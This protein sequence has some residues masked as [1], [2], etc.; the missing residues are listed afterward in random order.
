MAVRAPCHPAPLMAGASLQRI[1]IYLG[2]SPGTDPA[3]AAGV[4]ALAREC[5][6]RGL[7]VVYGGGDVGL[8]GVL[9]DAALAAGGE[10]IGVIPEGLL[11]R[12]VGH[13][14]LSDLR[15]VGSMHERKALM[16]EL[17]DAF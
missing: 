10:V 2:S 11:L 13:R 14:G 15:V 3:Y 9:A 17:S 8:M 4:E 1:C 12:E 5:A 16:E 6:G 7:G